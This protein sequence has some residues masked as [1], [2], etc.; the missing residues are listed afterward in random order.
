[1]NDNWLDDALS[2]FH[3]SQTKELPTLKQKTEQ[4]KLSKASAFTYIIDSGIY[5]TIARFSTL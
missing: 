4:S 5:E 3:N 2:E 1:M